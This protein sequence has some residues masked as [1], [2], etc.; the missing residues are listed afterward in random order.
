[1]MQ[2]TSPIREPSDL[3]SALRIFR[4]QRFDSLLSCA[5]IRDFFI[6]RYRPDGEPASVTYDYHARQMR[7][8][9]ERRY[10]ENGSF[11]I[12]TPELL[13]RTRNRLGRRIGLYVMDRYKMHQV[14]T[15]EDLT[16]CQVIMRGYGLAS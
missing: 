15:E 8:A 7:Q 4:E 5:E 2:A 12:F 1:G 11:Y 6:W 13:R 3:E 16:L 14:D 9:I 10:L